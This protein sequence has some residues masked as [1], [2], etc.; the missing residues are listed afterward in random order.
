MKSF[1]RIKLAIFAMLAASLEVAAPRRDTISG[2][3]LKQ[4]GF[5]LLGAR[6]YAGYAGG[7]IVELPASTEASLIASGQAVTSVGPPTSGP[8]T[9]TATSGCVTVAAAAASI[10]VTNPLVTVQSIIMAVVAQ[11][12]AD[13]TFLRVERVVAA[14]GSFTIFGTAAATAATM[15]DWAIINPN[16]SLTNPQ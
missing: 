1:S 14:A 6:G 15:V 10:V 12:A 9:T 7:T 13:G 11:A 16:G 4:G 5:V 3:R 2:M 8:V